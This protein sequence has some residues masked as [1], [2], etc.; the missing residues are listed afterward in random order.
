MRVILGYDTD[1]QEDTKTMVLEDHK[2]NKKILALWL[3][4]K[5]LERT[6]RRPDRS[7]KPSFIKK[8]FVQD[9]LDMPCSRL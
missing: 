5:E 2:I 1:L 8:A 6:S 3:E 9:V 4:W 7:S